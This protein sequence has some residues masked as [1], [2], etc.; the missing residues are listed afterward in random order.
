MKLPAQSLADAKIVLDRERAELDPRFPEDRCLYV[1]RDLET[2]QALITEA[3]SAYVSKRPFRWFFTGHTGA[4]K[5]T[6]L[7]RIVASAEVIEH[8]VPYIYRV[9]DNL[10]VHNLDFTDLILG[11]AQSVASVASTSKV[12]VSK[13]LHHRMDKWG[14][15]TELETELGISGTGKTGIEFNAL[16]FKA[17]A[18]VQAG[19]EKRKI[20]REKLHESLTDF[21]KLIDDLVAAVEKKEKKRVL[22]I[23]DTLDHVDHRPIR[24]IFTNH[25]ASLSR[26]KVSL[27]TV[28]PLPML[29]EP[30]FMAAVST[31]VS[32]LPNVKVYSSPNSAGLDA[33]GFDFFRTV[34]S[35]LA[36]LNLFSD[37]AL[38]ELFRLSG[39]MLR[40]MIGL[41]GDACKYADIDKA[42]Q[43]DPKHCTRVLDERKAFFRRLLK[44]SDYEILRMLRDNPRPLGIEGLGPL[45]DLKAVIFYPNGEGWYGL[46]PAVQSILDAAAR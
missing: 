2:H 11:I 25:W 42:D 10:D 30:Q 1:D 32:L 27:L 22:V 40:D 19:G 31:N 14:S 13:A 20:V 17:S 3:Q 36:E 26:P 18:E 38:R 7:N 29:F 6:E 9:R 46:N 8:Y 28:I 35:R 15:D 33:G 5:S 37:D 34:L 24:D 4:G 21:I 16:V 43:V 44:G 41:A 12:T 39:G 45:L 23:I